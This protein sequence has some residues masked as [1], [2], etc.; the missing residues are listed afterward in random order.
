MANVYSNNFLVPFYQSDLS[1]KMMI[2]ALLNVALHISGEQS[3]FLG[4]GEEWLREHYQMFWVITEYHLEITRL[5]T[6]TEK[7]KIETE[8]VGYNKFFCYRDFRFFDEENT[9]ILTIHSTWV[10]MDEKSRKIMKVVDEIIQPYETVQ[11]KK[12]IRGHRFQNFSDL[13]KN[14]ELISEDYN[15]RFSDIDMNQHVNNSK[16]YDW[17]TAPLD[18]NFLSHYFPVE[19]FIKYQH[20]VLYGEKVKSYVLKQ[21]MTSYHSINEDKCQIEITWK[22]D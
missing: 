18:L 11:I 16:Y 15:I 13:K 6:F 14:N 4:R 5:P 9:L 2:P 10:L 8:S 12:I 22:K 19:I 20:E 21:G 17:A 3:D 7:I 1:G